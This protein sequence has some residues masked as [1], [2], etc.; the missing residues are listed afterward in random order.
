M[1]ILFCKVNSQVW[2]SR[3]LNATRSST[4]LIQG[5]AR[6]MEL[7]KHQGRNTIDSS[8]QTS[9][10]W[11]PGLPSSWSTPNLHHSVLTSPH[12]APNLL[13]SAY[14]SSYVILLIP[15]WVFHNLRKLQTT[16]RISW[17]VPNGSRESHMQPS[18]KILLPQCK[19]SILHACLGVTHETASAADLRVLMQSVNPR[20]LRSTKDRMAFKIMM[21]QHDKCTLLAFLSF[22]AI[23]C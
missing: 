12:F 13:N 19:P 6:E 5:W 22:F 8:P 10:C 2:F 18:G 9:C 7:F 1:R 17:R 20:F 3:G 14:S 23:F 21:I 11:G 15:N 4:R 16:S